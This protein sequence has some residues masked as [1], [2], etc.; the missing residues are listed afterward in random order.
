MMSA[1]LAVCSSNVRAAPAQCVYAPGGSGIGGTGNTLPIAGNV[2]FSQGAVAAQWGGKSRPLATGDAVCVGETIVTAPAAAAQ[3]KM[4]DDGLV[5]IRARTQ[6]SIEKYAYNGNPQDHSM[7]ALL[8]GALRVVTGKIGKFHPKNDYIKTPTAVIGV[9]GTDHEATVIEA[10][11][12]SG[13]AAG[14]YDK[15]NEGVTFI[16]TD[17]GEIEIHPDQVGFAGA[18]DDIPTILHEMP[19]FYH[20]QPGLQHGG[21]SAESGNHREAL[22]EHGK[23]SDLRESMEGGKL[24]H[25][26]AAGE[27]ADI[28]HGAELPERSER[29]ELPERPEAPELPE[30]PEH[31]DIP[32]VPEHGEH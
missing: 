30:L 22:G 1:V 8:K 16:Q 29:P 5:A 9:R 6:F 15:V 31:P 24:E 26:E 13:Y 27:H 2:T 19:G 20:G 11:D 10:G 28:H 12:E 25:V 21:V 3:I 32:E 7:F 14:T 4:T 18:A 17:K 23:A